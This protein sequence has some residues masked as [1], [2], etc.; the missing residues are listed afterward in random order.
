VIQVEPIP[1]ELIRTLTAREREVFDL[2]GRGFDRLD[3]AKELFR[4]VR[5][6]DA[7][8]SSI[9]KKLGAYGK[10]I[11]WL[12]AMAARSET[13]GPG[14][15]SNLTLADRSRGGKTSM[16]QQVRNARGRFAGKQT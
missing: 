2:I 14:K 6:I 11:N 4:S 1:I 7:H 15:G 13:V 5:T 12:P 9:A 3:I 10:G 8:R 16:Q